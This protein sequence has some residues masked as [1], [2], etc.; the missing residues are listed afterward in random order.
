VGGLDLLRVGGDLV[1]RVGGLESP[2]PDAE[3]RVLGEDPRGGREIVGAEEQAELADALADGAP[4]GDGGDGAED[5]DCR[6]RGAPPTSA[7]GV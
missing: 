5:G 4:D 6:E 7:R 1:E 3:Q 2:G